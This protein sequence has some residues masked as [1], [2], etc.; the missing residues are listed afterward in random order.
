VLYPE[1]ILDHITAN[2][3]LTLYYNSEIWLLPKLNP[4]LKKLLLAAS[5]MA[6]K[7]C[8]SSYN[9]SMSQVQIHVINKRAA[10]SQM[11]I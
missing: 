5:A 3:Y 11:M 10:P 7:L 8:T 9:H 2:F 1:G 6:L 4:F